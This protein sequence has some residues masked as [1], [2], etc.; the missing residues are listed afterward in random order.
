MV[1]N[2][3]LLSI[4]NFDLRLQHLLIIGIL[5]LSFSISM[6]FRAQPVTYGYELFEFD[7]FFNFKSTNYLIEN[8]PEAYFDWVDERSWHP[9]GRNISETSQSSLHLITAGFYTI[10]GFSTSLYSFTILLPMIIGSI[11]GIVVF[12]FVRVIGGTTAG[13]FA[14]LIFSV[15][16]PIITRG[17]IGWFKSEPLSLFLGFLALYFFVSGIKF[18]KGKISAA[19]LIFGAL[20]L[21]LSLS[22]WGGG[23]FFVLSIVVFFLI[24]PFVKNEKNFLLWSVPVFSISLIIF[25]LLFE[26]TAYFILGSGIGFA[27]IAIILPT[28]FVVICEIIKNK[29]SEK[30]K[31]RNSFFFVVSI[32]ITG[33]GVF[34]SGVIK[35]PTF[36]YQNALN[37]FLTTQDPLTDSVAEHLTTDL[38]FSFTFL[39]VFI[40]FALIGIWFLF[41]LKT[42]NLKNDMRLFAL[43][44]GFIA[45]YVSSA[46]IRLEL[47]ASV[48]VLILGSIGLAVLLNKIYEQKDQVKLKIIFSVVIVGLFVTP[49]ILPED[50]SWINW[51][52]FS[53]SILGGGSIYSQHSSDDWPEAMKWI[54][55]NTPENAVIASWWDYGYWI[56][57]LSDRSTVVDNATLIDW[58]I[59]K[60]AYSLMTT[61]E[62]SANILGSDYSRDVSEY[63]TDENILLWGGE[64]EKEFLKNHTSKMFFDDFTKPYD[65]L[66]EEEKKLLDSYISENGVMECKPI[67]KKEAYNLGVEERSCNPITKGMDA[68]YIVIYVV[69]ERFYAEGANVPL[70]T[71]EGGGDESKKSWFAKISSQQTSKFIQADNI[72][73]TNYFM[74]SSTLGKLIPFSIVA[75][76]EPNTGRTFDNYMDGFIAVYQKEI[77]FSDPDNDPFVLVHAS[78][79]FHSSQPGIMTT[80]LIYKINPN[81]VN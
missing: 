71:L 16:V 68:D 53:P 22:A 13:L 12:A 7:P 18:N 47:F 61:P 2:L 43:V 48:A 40:I 62:N 70:Y 28:I 19:K 27:G 75:Y 11:T 64:F 57:A 67:F 32:I 15:S 25:S 30:T 80:V 79:S 5:I 41:S 74:E 66:N 50:R 46:F 8:G 69:G 56:S 34:A 72:T 45:L 35:L 33:V 38:Q 36:R 4:G 73:P 52:D 3:K 63:L 31:I 78:P 81:F 29:S 42:I 14:A 54:K 1:S 23:L 9:F 39:T 20:F 60:M 24:L 59:K 37:P 6:L 55:D 26:R 77:K 10:F 44:S 51:T 49:I 17:L 65:K 76:V 21:A 58:Q